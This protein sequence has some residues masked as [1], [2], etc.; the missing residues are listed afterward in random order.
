M[1]INKPRRSKKHN[2]AIVEGE[3]SL[4]KSGE[5]RIKDEEENSFYV[6]EV[7]NLDHRV[8][9]HIRLGKIKPD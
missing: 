3:K 6:G 2:P 5:Y 1:G 4:A 9:Q 8:K 7:Y